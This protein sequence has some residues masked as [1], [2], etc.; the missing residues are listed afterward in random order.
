VRERER[1]T[2]RVRERERESQRERERSKTYSR[3]MPTIWDNGWIRKAVPIAISKHLQG[4][5]EEEEEEPLLS[6]RPFFSFSFGVQR[7]V[8]E[9]IHDFGAQHRK[10]GSRFPSVRFLQRSFEIRR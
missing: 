9:R 5:H 4:Q 3:I 7:L 8:R 2:E 6:L 10:L 1:E